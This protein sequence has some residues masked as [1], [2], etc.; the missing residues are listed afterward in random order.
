MKKQ[1]LTTTLLS[2]LLITAIAGILFVNPAATNPLVE[3]PPQPAIGVISPEKN[4]VYAIN[5]VSLA[6]K[7][8]IQNWYS[9]YP[10]DTLIVKYFIG[11]LQGELYGEDALTP[12]SANVTE[13]RDGF[14]KASVTATARWDTAQGVYETFVS[15]GDIYFTID[16][17]LPSVQILVNQGKIYETSDV[18]LNFTV[19]EAVSWLGYSLDGKEA[20]T[21]TDTAVRDRRFGRDEYCI[22]LNGVSDGSHSLTVHA[23][24]DAGN[25]GESEPFQFTVGQE[26]QSETEQTFPTVLVTTASVSVTVAGILTG[27]LLYFK[28]YK[29]K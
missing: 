15:S 16:T 20:V 8:S 18:P 14:Y 28:R 13:L 12:F 17:T 6:F 7:V 25:T 10:P 24:D 9:T 19:S 29:R 22:M 23:K 5:S 1:I 26:E 11:G 27:F 21:V 4:E 3:P 2:A